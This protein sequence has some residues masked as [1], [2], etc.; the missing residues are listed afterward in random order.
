MESLYKKKVL[1]LG[2]SELQ[3]PA[4]LS[5]KE[6]S[7][8]T[9]VVDM[10]EKAT[11]IGYA[12]EF[13]N[14]STIDCDAILKLAKEKKIDGIMTI[15]SD[16]PMK[17]V[18][19]V[20]EALGL[21]T[22]SEDTALKVTNKGAMRE[23]LKKGNVPIP[24][25]Y[26]SNNENDFIQNS[27]SFPL[28][29]IVKPSD[30]SG[31]RGVTLVEKAEDALPAYRYARNNCSDGAVLIEE[32]MVGPEVSVEIFVT[33]EP[34]VIQITDKITTG[35]PH[36][37]EMGHTQPSRLPAEVINEIKAV[38]IDAVRALG[39][40]S[41]PAHAELIVTEK[42]AKIV[43]VGARLGGDYITTDLVPLSTGV[44][45]VKA[46]VLCALDEEVDI[47]KKF[48]R[49]SAVR[50]FSFDSYIN[51]NSNV[52]DMIQRMYVNKMDKREIMSSRDRE[53][54]YIVSAA[55]FDELEEKIIYINSY[56]K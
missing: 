33:D 37:V 27:K 30:N 3:V 34:N 28:P 42:G 48:S 29:F 21:H 35:A 47:E 6:S 56:I 18:A 41:G 11:G 45:M 44:D 39:I 16:R 32:Y 15:C 46:T 23:A 52:S 8:K 55:D 13:Y 40:S 31:S 5:A 10:D 51:I 12:D 14:I 17:V 36:F 1:I 38:A 54:F 2:A 20:G 4:I 53:G 50:Y 9:I 43:E 19:K 25:Y 7:I 49:V 22:I 24:L 26:V